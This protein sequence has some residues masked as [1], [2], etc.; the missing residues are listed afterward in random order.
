MYIKIFDKEEYDG[1]WFPEKASEFMAWFNEKLEQIPAEHRD[2]ARIEIGSI[3]SYEDSHYVT[4]E[5]SYS[6]PDTEEEIAANELHMA[7]QAE[8]RRKSE[9][10]LLADLKSKYE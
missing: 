1:D 10:Q 5:I 8:R 9:M 2:A 3:A 4:L 6:R 7:Y